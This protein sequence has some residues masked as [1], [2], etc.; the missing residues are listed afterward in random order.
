M[1]QNGTLLILQPD[2]GKEYRFWTHRD[3]RSVTEPPPTLL[4]AI[5]MEPSVKY[6][7][8]YGERERWVY[9]GESFASPVEDVNPEATDLLHRRYFKNEDDQESPR[10]MVTVHGPMVISF[11]PGEP[12]QQDLCE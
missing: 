6:R 1:S 7:I 5:F 8:P 4:D 11:P 3:P 10:T 2:G 12:P 9:V